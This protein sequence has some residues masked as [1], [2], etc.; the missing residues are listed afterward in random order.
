MANIY[1]IGGG[2]T[3]S[4][5]LAEA[6]NYDV[7]ALPGGGDTLVIDPSHAGWANAPNKCGAELSVGGL[8]QI[9]TDVSALAT[10]GNLTVHGAAATQDA[11]FDRAAVGGGTI[12]SFSAVLTLAAGE[13]GGCGDI[14]LNVGVSS[15]PVTLTNDSSEEGVQ[16]TGKRILLAGTHSGSLT[17]NGSGSVGRGA[18][19]VLCGTHTGTITHNPAGAVGLGATGDASAATLDLYSPCAF[20]G[21]TFGVLNVRQGVCAVISGV[22]AGSD[23]VFTVANGY[24]A[25]EV[26]FD[27]TYGVCTIGVFY[28]RVAA[29]R[30]KLLAA[31]TASSM[32]VDAS[33][34]PAGGGAPVVI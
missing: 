11:S 15:A 9:G 28:P 34:L 23:C 7:A 33:L 1:F 2:S 13:E 22:A 20:I 18:M 25:G 12:T 31:G 21:G 16:E 3:D 26:L 8:A 10:T 19:N 30:P 4:G 32:T 5:D 14:T 6:D 27:G 17:S 29:C 24:H